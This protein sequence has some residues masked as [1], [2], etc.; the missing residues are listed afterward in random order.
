MMELSELLRKQEHRNKKLPENVV[1]LF[2]IKINYRSGISEKL[3]F[4]V[5]EV[6]KTGNYLSVNY[7]TAFES[8]TPFFFN[9]KDIES[10]YQLDTA[11]VTNI[12]GTYWDD[13][14]D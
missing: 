13:T 14:T 7:E 5:F 6:N 9:P 8:N 2:L 12:D 3:W 4:K 10:I 11:Y 1:E